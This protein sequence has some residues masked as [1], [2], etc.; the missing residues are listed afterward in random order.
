M[1]DTLPDEAVLKNFVISEGDEQPR[2]DVDE[3]PLMY[4]AA[5]EEARSHYAL[6]ASFQNDPV[7]Y[8]TDLPLDLSQQEAV[9][10]EAAT[11]TGVRL[12]ALKLLERAHPEESTAD[13]QAF[14]EELIVGVGDVCCNRFVGPQRI[15]GE[16]YRPAWKLA[17]LLGGQS[18][19][20]SVSGKPL[21]VI[22]AEMKKHLNP[23]GEIQRLE[24]RASVPTPWGRDTH[25]LTV[26]A[27][28]EEPIEVTLQRRGEATWRSEQGPLFNRT[29][30]FFAGRVGEA[31]TLRARSDVAADD[32]EAIGT[33]VFDIT[34]RARL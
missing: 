9:Y 17:Y 19:A 30:Q 5:F 16:A 12:D 27:K 25:G 34:R 23:D 11:L 20:R 18:M 28:Q 4:T 24:L 10:D 29:L 8:V 2:A 1:I 31:A 21:R 32:R 13:P 15:D 7:A 14:A 22:L 6:E 33:A 3:R 26:P